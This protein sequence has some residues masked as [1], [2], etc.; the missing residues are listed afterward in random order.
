MR[1]AIKAAAILLAM[2]MLASF[3][4]GCRPPKQYLFKQEFIEGKG[5]QHIRNPVTEEYKLK[6]CDYDNNG[7]RTTCKE[8]TILVERE[9][10]TML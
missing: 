6:V 9:T 7:K 5:V 10:E 3:L 2:T 8:S 4:V 1:V